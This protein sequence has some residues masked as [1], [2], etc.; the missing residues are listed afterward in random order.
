MAKTKTLTIKEQQ[1]IYTKSSQL[2]YMEQITWL[3]S[4]K[5]RVF[6]QTISFIT[7]LVIYSIKNCGLSSTLLT[8]A[9]I[10]LI[11]SHDQTIF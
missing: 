10:G 6:R 7:V 3:C 2:N 5:N 4:I 11:L 1:T 9:F 8:A